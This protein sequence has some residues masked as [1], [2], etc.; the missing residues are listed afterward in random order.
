MIQTY[1]PFLTGGGTVHPFPNFVFPNTATQTDSPKDDYYVCVIE[2]PDITHHEHTFV[3][4]CNVSF[5]LSEIK[6]RIQ[7][8]VKV[9]L[10]DILISKTN[11]H[12]MQC[13]LVVV[14]CTTLCSP[15]IP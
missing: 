9:T 3:E 6:V 4:P 12:G 7:R 15:Q 5:K 14:M 11:P 8:V 13:M 10:N 1:S 2:S